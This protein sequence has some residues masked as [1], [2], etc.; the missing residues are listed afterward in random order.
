MG[1][2]TM[3]ECSAQQATVHAKARKQAA[4]AH[5]GRQAKPEMTTP[6]GGSSSLSPSHIPLYLLNSA[7]RAPGTNR[8]ASTA[9]ATAKLAPAPA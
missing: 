5:A 3:G 6:K 8:A 9:P 4:Q 1:Q 7:S 2:H